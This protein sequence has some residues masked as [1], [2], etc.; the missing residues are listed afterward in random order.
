VPEAPGTNQPRL[1]RAEAPPEGCGVTSIHLRDGTRVASGEWRVASG[2]WRVASGEWR[3]AGGA[4]L[5]WRGSGVTMVTGGEW[6]VKE[7]ALTWV[8]FDLNKNYECNRG[9]C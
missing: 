1:H 6:R 4:Y 2:E 7:P 8:K 9:N 3:V 5:R